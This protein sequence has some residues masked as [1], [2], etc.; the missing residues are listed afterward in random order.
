MSQNLVLSIIVP[1]YNTAP[2]LRK[3]LDSIC[4]QSYKELEIICVND[5]STDNSADILEEYAARD[6]RIKVFTQKNAGL[7][8]ARN[9]G[10]KNATGEWITGVDSDDWL[11]P[12]VYEKAMGC[13][14]DAVD[15]VFF[16]VQNVD[17]AGDILPHSSYFDL[18]AAGVYSL[19]SKKT[20]YLNVCFVTKLWRRSLIEDNHL[21]FPVG[22]VH[23]DEAMYALAAP[24][25]RKISICP[26]IGYAYTQRENSIM[27]EAG[28]D[29]LRRIRRFI[30][31]AEFVY[32]EYKKRNLL[33]SPARKHLLRLVKGMC[34]QIHALEQQELKHSAIKE[35]F[36]LIEKYGM[37]EED[38]AIERMQPYTRRGILTI[39]RHRC[40][41]L[42]RIWGIPIWMKGYTFSGH[43]LT[44]GM[45]LYHIKNRLAGILF[46]GRH[47]NSSS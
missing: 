36:P 4:S 1:I 7:S 22:L 39:T 13:I 20:F 32:T 27:R 8:A 34:M 19:S 5:G 28:L 14:N 10:L 25:V 37:L 46:R 9:T 42:Y 21:R 23:E 16:G 35:I 41:K 17:E 43:P 40:A 6:S 12:G 31:I 11:Y 24:Y 2:W 45:L 33:H 18:P 15:M 30:P 3:C 29:E 44:P 26:S 38:Y 47:P